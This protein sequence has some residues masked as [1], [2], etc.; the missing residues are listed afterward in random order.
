M[1]WSTAT[2]KQTWN[3]LHFHLGAV[4]S[5][6]TITLMETWKPTATVTYFLLFGLTFLCGYF[7]SNHH[8]MEEHTKHLYN[9][10][11]WNLKIWMSNIIQVEHIIFIHIFVYAYIYL[12][13][14]IKNKTHEFK[15]EKGWYIG[16]LER[17]KG[18]R[19]SYNYT[20]ILMNCEQSLRLID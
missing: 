14:T 2:Y 13:T 7:L 11:L 4:G 5:E 16:G 9:F 19:K 20:A 6:L 3:W 12:V 17:E 18:R 8:S 15:R 10:K 1:A